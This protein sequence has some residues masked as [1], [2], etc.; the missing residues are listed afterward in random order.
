MFSPHIGVVRYVHPHCLQDTVPPAVLP[1]VAGTVLRSHNWQRVQIPH[2]PTAVQRQLDICTSIQPHQHHRWLQKSLVKPLALLRL[3]RQR[4][5]VHRA[6]RERNHWCQAKVHRPRQY[7]A[8]VHF[9][10]KTPNLLVVAVSCSHVDR[11]LQV[12]PWRHVSRLAAQG[13][14]DTRQ[15]RV[16]LLQHSL[17]CQLSLGGVQQPANSSAQCRIDSRS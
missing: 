15:H 7:N 6:C 17:H 11:G 13:M 9:C 10:C 3:L 12:Q 14:S 16:Q 1:P 5:S 4:T 8:E 2:K